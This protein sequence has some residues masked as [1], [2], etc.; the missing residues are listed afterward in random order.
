MRRALTVGLFLVAGCGRTSGFLRDANSINEHQ[1]RMEIAA[2]G[3]A[4]SVSGSS[5]IG[6]LFC[7]FPMKNG[8]YKDAMAAL[9]AEAKLQTNEVIESIREDHAFIAYIFYCEDR[10]IISADVYGVA[11]VA[12]PAQAQHPQRSAYD[13]PYSIDFEGR[14][15]FKR[16]CVSSDPSNPSDPHKPPPPDPYA[17]GAPGIGDAGAFPW[18]PRE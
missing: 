10:L 7:I 6:L 18:G 5:T 13:P 14:M 8:A 12:T 1:F 15:I 4:R 11:A 2:Q 3:Y 17:P 16:E 9:H